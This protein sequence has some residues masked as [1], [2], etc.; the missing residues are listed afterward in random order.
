MPFQPIAGF[1]SVPNSRTTVTLCSSCGFRQSRQPRTWPSQPHVQSPVAQWPCR[2]I[3][4]RE[5]GN[6]GNLTGDLSRHERD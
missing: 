6:S 4:S 5:F 1:G 2:Q 3:C